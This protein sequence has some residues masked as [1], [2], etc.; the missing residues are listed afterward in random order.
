MPSPL[1]QPPCIVAPRDARRLARATLDRSPPA[2]GSPLWEA[3]HRIAGRERISAVWLAR[4]LARF[5][6]TEDQCRLMGGDAMR[7]RAHAALK[8]Y[9]SGRPMDGRW[10]TE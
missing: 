4:Q 5:G 7:R 3:A 1:D 6:L 8:R 9:R 10:A 2:F